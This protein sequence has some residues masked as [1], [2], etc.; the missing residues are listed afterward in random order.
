MITDPCYTED[1]EKNI[2]DHCQVALEVSDSFFEGFSFK[3]EE[4]EDEE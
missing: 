2:R 1:G 4:N 3:E